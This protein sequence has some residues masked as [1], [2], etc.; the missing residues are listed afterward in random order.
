MVN[1]LAK[2]KASMIAA[3]ATIIGISTLILTAIFM[4]FVTPGANVYVIALGSLA[5]IVT[6]HFIQWLVGPKILESAYNVEPIM[7]GKLAWVEDIVARVARASG[8]GFVPKAMLARVD[9]PN[10]FA[11]GNSLTG[12]KV[13]VTEGLIRS[14]PKD[15]IEAVIAHEIGHIKHRDVE[16]MMVISLLPAII[17]WIG[18]MLMYFGWFG[19]E[20]ESEASLLPLIGMV[21]MGVSFLF[22]FAV[23]YVSRLREYYA[24][25]HAALTIPN[26]ARRLQRALARILVISGEL[27]RF[28]PSKVASAGKFKAFLIADPEEGIVV[29]GGAVDIDEVVE[30]IKSQPRLTATE[31]FMT[32]PDPAKRLRFLDKLASM[33]PA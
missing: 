18:R 7:G 31:I 17:F 15:E 12:Y 20:R 32:H 9:V 29:R 23:L 3:L 13:A 26:G 19:D 14:V 27:K 21:L 24:D 25:A 16:L 4:F 28:A 30:W 10:A 22:N 5:F 11:Y 6:I 33:A 8:L 1:V 2:L